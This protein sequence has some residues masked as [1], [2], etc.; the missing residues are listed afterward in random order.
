MTMPKVTVYIVSRDYAR[1]LPEAIESVMRQTLRDWELIVIDD[2]STDDT[3][4]VLARYEA[5]PRVRIVHQP[6]RGLIAS[7]NTAL[8]MARGEYIVRLDGDDYFDENALLVLAGVLDANPD[9][10]LVFP[11]YYVI[12][13]AGELVEHVRR[14]KVDDEVR[15]LDQPAHGAGTMI[16][17]Q[18]LVDFGGYDES[19][20][21]QDGYDLWLK[22]I[23][24]L[25]VYNVNL[26][27]FYYRRHP[28]SLT[29]NR[30]RILRARRML[31]ARHVEERYGGAL[32]PVLAL[33]PVR[34][35]SPLG[36]GWALRPLGARRVLDYTLDA[37]TG[38][39]HVR[40]IV[41][42]EDP[43]ID[44][45]ARARGV[46]TMSRPPELARP[47]SPIEPTVLHA[48]AHVRKAGFD[49]EVVCLTYANAPLR[50]AEHVEEAIN[51]LLL[52]KPDSVISVCQ[53][54]RLHYQHRLNGLEPLFKRRE[55]LLERETLYQENGAIYTSWARVITDTSFVGASVG[56]IIMTEESSVQLDS[57]YESWLA[58]KLLEV[59]GTP[60]AEGWDL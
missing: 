27:L 19:V 47:N 3:P 11:D 43:E 52:F 45:Y 46:E 10:G 12:T 25:R 6:P 18:S 42:T 58:E 4:R 22:C 1:F 60:V 23:D 51:T 14:K 26:P 8:R 16:R 40:G 30:E 37:L 41:V 56:H 29:T 35:T 21:C 54:R 2:G 44:A 32:P 59:R 34:N 36:S 53:S 5:D 9:V 15:L 24:R 50:R 38:L 20:D 31:K 55:L 33:V 49:P 28:V 48:L 39:R 57:A 7:C 13:S 17:R